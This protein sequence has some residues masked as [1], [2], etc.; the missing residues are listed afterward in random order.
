MSVTIVEVKSKQQLKEFIRFP[1]KL[2]RGCANWV[3]ALENDE[4]DTLRRETNGAYDYCDAQ[5]FLA[6][7]N[8]QIAGRVAAIINNLAN[9]TWGDQTVRF[10]WLDFIEDQEVLN[11]LL[12]AVSKWGAARGCNIMKGPFGFTDMDKEGAL[13][14]GFEHL[15]PFTCL[16]NY[17]YYDRLLTAAGLT[18]D[19]DWTQRVALVKKEEPQMFEFAEA[20]EKRF[21]IHVAK[22]RTTREFCRKYG[23]EI[24]HMYNTTFSE[25][26]QFTPISDRQIKRYL[27]TYV[28]ILIPDFVAVC[29]D[30]NDK[31]IGFTFCVP[32]LSKAVKRSDGRLFPFGIFRI[33]KALRKNDTLEALM[34]GVLPEYQ[35]KG[36]NVL[37]FKYIHENCL[38]RGITK[39]ILNPQ[40]EDN[41]KVQSLF[42][43]YETLPYMRR[44]AYTK[45]I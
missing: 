36:A 11:T 27:A 1:Y 35:G 44:R 3:P 34:I 13:V 16:Y 5:L 37:M 38:K 42:Q 43:Q 25:L 9:K 32:S 8:G 39:M 18:K 12:D 23:L 10:G 17:P 4:Y 21:G 41:F 28:P 40:L 14:E 30:S 2:Y 20:I 19:V 22:A 24:F 31:P 15:S 45:A 29:V 7:I 33:L 6:Y 26:F